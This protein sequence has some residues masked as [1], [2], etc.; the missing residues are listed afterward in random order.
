MNGMP[1][2]PVPH[3]PDW[4][5][6]LE[7][8]DSG[9]AAHTRQ[10]VKRAGRSDVCSV[11]GDS[12]TLDYKVVGSDLPANAVGTIRLCGDCRSMREMIHGEKYEPFRPM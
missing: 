12:P 1:L 7:T 11:C 9:Q 2:Y 5:D 6:A 3:S 8:F 10:I 4:F